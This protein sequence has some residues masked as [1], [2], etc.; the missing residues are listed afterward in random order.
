[1]VLP[2]DRMTEEIF[3]IPNTTAA[4][5]GGSRPSCFSYSF[6]ATA[7]YSSTMSLMTPVKEPF[8]AFA[9]CDGSR[10]APHGRR[11]LLYRRGKKAIL[12]Q[13]SCSR[14]ARRAANAAIVAAD[15]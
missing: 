8:M 1:M 3:F 5:T 13:F 9:L 2:L 15:N 4:R 10:R 7:I 12:V 11:T 6:A 14:A